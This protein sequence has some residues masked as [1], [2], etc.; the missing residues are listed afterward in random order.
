MPFAR[1]FW[2]RGEASKHFAV[3]FQEF[4]AIGQ[5]LAVLLSG[6]SIVLPDPEAEGA[7][8]R[9]FVRRQNG[10]SKGAHFRVRQLSLGL[11]LPICLTGILNITRPAC[12]RFR[13]FIPTII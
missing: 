2:S 8:S 12:I 5:C 3:Y 6:L 9:S 10:I 13:I 11:A 7:Q 1:A 4:V